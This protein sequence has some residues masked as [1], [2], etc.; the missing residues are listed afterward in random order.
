MS[1][2]YNLLINNY[3]TLLKYKINLPPEEFY[4]IYKETYM[5]TKILD[6]NKSY[7]YNLN[8]NKKI[9]ILKKIFKLFKSDKNII[10]LTI[11]MCKI[12]YYLIYIINT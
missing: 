7:T 5:Y 1:E 11:Y 6:L 9:N 4:K 3:N 8:L 12:H 2:K 10:N